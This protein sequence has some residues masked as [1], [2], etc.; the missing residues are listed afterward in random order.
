MTA[1]FDELMAAVACSC[2]EARTRYCTT[3]CR[4]CML[5]HRD[6]TGMANAAGCQDPDQHHGS[7]M[8][9]EITLLA[10]AGGGAQL[11]TACGHHAHV[12]AR[13]VTATQGM[14]YAACQAKVLS[15]STRLWTQRRTCC[16]LHAWCEAGQ[17]SALRGILCCKENSA[18]EL[19]FQAGPL[20]RHSG[21]PSTDSR[22]QFTKNHS[23]ARLSFTILQHEQSL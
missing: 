11:Y 5:L 13:G 18:V 2:S 12:E 8:L 21:M 6:S 7:G 23:A 4:S 14:A 3:R 1:T 19:S 17:K 9:D 22:Q 16:R 20:L 15:W 10:S